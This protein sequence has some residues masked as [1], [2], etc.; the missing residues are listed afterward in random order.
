MS[1]CTPENSAI[2]KLSVIIIIITAPP[3]L[4]L[5]TSY[6]GHSMP[7]EGCGGHSMPVVGCG[8][9]SMPVEGCGGHSMPVVGCGGDS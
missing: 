5:L 1:L 3:C 6:G 9:H 4:P 8:G 7:V 2:Q